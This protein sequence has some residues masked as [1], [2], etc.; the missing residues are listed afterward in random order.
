MAT[1]LDALTEEAIGWLRRGHADRAAPLVA[2]MC[3]LLSDRPEVARQMRRIVALV[4]FEWPARRAVAQAAM[5][6]PP[7]PADVEIVA[8]H[9]AAEAQAQLPAFEYPALL[10]QLFESAR[11]RSPRARCILLT[12][13]HTALPDF[14]AAV[15]VR[16]VALDRA[17]L[18]YERMRAQRDHLRR[19]PAGRATVFVDADVVVNAEP[20]GVFAEA[21]DVGLTLRAVVDAPFNGGV[22]FAGPGEGAARFF[23]QALACYDAL[24]D[25]PSIAPLFPKSLRCWWGDQFA[26]AALVGWRALA[27]RG[28]AATLSIDGLRVR[29]FP[30]ETHNYTIEARAYGPGELDARYFIH[31]KGARKQM[32]EFYLQNLRGQ[33]TSAN[34]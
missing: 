2:E 3:E 19:R 33:A 1:R 11:L 10:A 9:A 22:I 31:F 28:T 8:F 17:H 14:G 15:E 20:S 34:P 24:A 27:E 13:E 5:V 23:T 21:F 32:M 6:R 12:D 29:V 26:L 25:A 4:S 18:M 30:C 7:D 16:R